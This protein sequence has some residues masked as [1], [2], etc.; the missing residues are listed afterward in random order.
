MSSPKPKSGSFL[1]GAAKLVSHLKNSRSPSRV[2]V[3][4]GSN[5]GSSR[6][7]VSKDRDTER[8]QERYEKATKQLKD[9][10]QVRQNDWKIFEYSELDNLS[11]REDP[12]KLQ[13]EI[14]KVLEAR[15]MSLQNKSNWDK[16]KG[17]VEFVFTTLS[18]F[19]KNVLSVATNMQSVIF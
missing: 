18:P 12:A 2:P 8:T 5:S 1:K 10:L 9:A 3:A 15:K 19:A 16:C 11:E 6:N 7:V 14:N 13:T 17:I 4:E